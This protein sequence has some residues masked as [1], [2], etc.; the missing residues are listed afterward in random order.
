MLLL[1]LYG[2]RMGGDA[3]EAAV[4][5]PNMCITLTAVSQLDATLSATP[6]LSA[7]LTATPTLA[8]TLA[9]AEC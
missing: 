1:L 5:T 6:T 8:V 7:T 2:L 3:S 4:A 9:A